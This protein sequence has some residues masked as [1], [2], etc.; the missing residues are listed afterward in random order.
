MYR[1]WQWTASR[2]RN[3]ARILPRIEKVLFDCLSHD[4]QRNLCPLLLKLIA[5]TRCD[6]SNLTI[7]SVSRAIHAESNCSRKQIAASD[8][9]PFFIK[10]VMRLAV[11]VLYKSILPVAEPQTTICWCFTCFSIVAQNDSFN[12]I[13]K[14]LDVFLCCSTQIQCRN[15]LASDFFVWIVARPVLSV[16][17]SYSVNLI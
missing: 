5:P 4:A 10:K 15:I 2:P 13:I 3:K 11:N 9:M 6:S 17:Y 12:C 14:W 16:Q 1:L 7:D 8:F